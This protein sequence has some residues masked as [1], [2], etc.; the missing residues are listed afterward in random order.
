MANLFPIIILTVSTILLLIGVGI[1][2]TA[3]YQSIED[4]N[5]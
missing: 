4:E 1:V 2:F 3:F 5:V